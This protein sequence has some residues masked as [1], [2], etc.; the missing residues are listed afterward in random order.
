MLT[1]LASG[2]DTLEATFRGAIRPLVLQNLQA[3]K[4]KAQQSEIPQPLTLG[5]VQL[6]VQPKGLAPWSY[7][8]T[9]EELHLRASGAKKLPC[10]SV[11]L[12]AFG[13]SYRGHEPLW[14]K[15]KD[16]AQL[17]GAEGGSISRLDLA[18]DFQG[19]VPTFEEM[20]SATCPSN[21]R[22][23]YPN[24]EEP[25][26]FQFGKG[27]IVVRVYNKSREM[28]KSGKLW[29]KEVW[30][31]HPDY[32]PEEDV[33][34]F[35]V[36]LRRERLRALGSVSVEDAF[37]LLQVYFV[38][39][40]YWVRPRERTE[41]NLSRCEVQG[42]WEELRGLFAGRPVPEVKPAKQVA[43]FAVL[44]P[45]MLGL[46]VSAAA[47]VGVTDLATALDLQGDAF[48]SYITSRGKLFE[49]RVRE[50]QR[51]LAH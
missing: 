31:K 20:R 25:E 13:L 36:Q 26:T 30:S 40:L 8:V 42:W 24:T 9:N 33:W 28:Q 38:I 49:E 39:G 34:R 18:V 11:R 5:D 48:R 50:R 32:R 47:S 29:L 23:V 10:A 41:A 43:G 6:V 46:L 19:H 3:A 27:D 12:S 2:V 45:Q 16:L 14:A 4:E 1:V 7:L 35:E 15:A 51:L 17:I 22:P 44:V 21:F 37:R